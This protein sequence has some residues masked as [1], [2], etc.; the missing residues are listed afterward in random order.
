MRILK[1]FSLADNLLKIVSISKQHDNDNLLFLNGARVLSIFWIIYGHDQWFR[2]SNIKNWTESL[3][4]LTKPGIP[5]LAP[6]AYFAVDTFF[7]IGGFLITMGMLE[8]LK[9]VKSFM[10]F[11]IGSIIHRFIRIWPTYMLAILMFWKVAPFLGDGPI[12]RSFYNITCSCNNGG[13]LWNMFFLD[14]FGDHGP[15]GLDY[16][17]G[18]VLVLPLRDGISLSIF[19]FL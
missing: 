7:W 14:N 2:L 18:W 11:Y 3:D 19:N 15:N 13:V 6:A 10:K 1:S 4:I 17:F 5:T 9:K 12:W 16:C 8:Q